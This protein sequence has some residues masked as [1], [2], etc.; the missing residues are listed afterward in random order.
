MNAIHSFRSRLSRYGDLVSEVFLS[1]RGLTVQ[2]AN[3]R[4]T[5]LILTIDQNELDVFM[6]GNPPARIKD[7]FDEAEDPQCAVAVLARQ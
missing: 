1:G 3:R 6:R 4:G 5:T 2:F 7:A